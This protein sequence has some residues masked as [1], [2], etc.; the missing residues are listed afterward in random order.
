MSSLLRSKWRVR[1]SRAG[2]FR[3]DVDFLSARG[4]G[5][6][7]PSM[8]STPKPPAGNP[9]PENSA[10]PGSDALDAPVR[11]LIDEV[12][13]LC[14]ALLPADLAADTALATDLYLTT[15]P[16]MQE[17]LYSMLS[18]RLGESAAVAVEPEEAADRPAKQAGRR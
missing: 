8:S 11:P 9:G 17:R 2:D 5:F 16:L 14:D 1:V 13:A 6:G 10:D 12:R 7:I 18:Q 4:L 15:H 3:W